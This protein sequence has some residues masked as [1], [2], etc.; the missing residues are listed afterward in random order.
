MHSTQAEILRSP[1]ERKAYERGVQKFNRAVLAW[2]RH[3]RGPRPLREDYVPGYPTPSGVYMDWGMLQEWNERDVAQ[4]ERDRLNQKIPPPYHTPRFQ[5]WLDRQMNRTDTFADYIRLRP[6]D[7]PLRDQ[8]KSLATEPKD[9]CGAHMV[10]LLPHQ[11]VVYA[12]AKLRALNKISSP[13][14]LAM[15]STGAGKTLEGLCAVLAFWDKRI[16]AGQ[17]YA[18]ICV[19]TRSNQNSNTARKLAQLALRFFSGGYTFRSF[20]PG[21][22]EYPFA[23]GTSLDAAEATILKRMQMGL[24]AV[25]SSPADALYLRDN[26]KDLYTY[27]TLANDVAKGRLGS[28]EHLLHHALVIADEVQFLLA[29]PAKELQYRDAYRLL[30]DALTSRRSLAS[31]WVL[32]LTATPGGTRAEACE[33]LNV[34]RGRPGFVTSANLPQKAMGLLSYAQVQGDLHH[35]PRLDLKPVCV[36][37]DPETAWASEYLRVATAFGRFHALIRDL[38]PEAMR[39]IDDNHQTRLTTYR[40]RV[41]TYRQAHRAWKANKR[42]KKADEPQPPQPPPPWSDRETSGPST[43]A[44]DPADRGAFYRRL[45]E[46]SNFI[47]L[48]GEPAE[49]DEREAALQAEKTVV[50]RVTDGTCKSEDGFLVACGPKL[51]QVVK[52]IGKT[53]GKHYVYTSSTTTLLL[54]A[55]LLE[56]ELGMEQ[57]GST[58]HGKKSCTPHTPVAGKKY[59]V[60]LGR[61]ASQRQLMNPAVDLGKWAFGDYPQ[62]L[63]RAAMAAVDMPDNMN[64]EHV[65]VVLTTSEDFKGVDLKGLRYIHLLEPMTD[66]SELIQLAGRGPRFC[67]H[68]GLRPVA[69]KWN[70]TL[71]AYRQMF[72]GAEGTDLNVD[73]HVLQQSIRRFQRQW[74]SD[75]EV[76]LQKASVDYHVFKDNIHQNVA[77]QNQKLLSQSCTPPE[78]HR[79]APT[80]I[81]PIMPLLPQEERKADFRAR[82]QRQLARLGLMDQA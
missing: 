34:V 61:A 63:R 13:G 32:A 58:C 70:V 38:N 51:S 75:T 52:H 19:S 23:V 15:H 42:A 5:V 37:S 53:A 59:F 82:K 48:R 73:S 12:M 14:L 40:E 80:R 35:F 76:A 60:L 17:Y 43:W 25:A 65:K 79:Q 64:G 57:L 46:A 10:D 81:R 1:T 68:A 4:R 7:A 72:E 71:L 41:D 69:S 28:G 36:V 18:I 44:Y 78:V 16:R 2:L 77:G 31:T 6:N 24:Q 29:P 26:R 55:A 45:R 20:V 27:T 50:L 33:I 9:G 39:E 22:P 8:L 30:K 11:A 62:A 74:G 47:F 67:S 21:L 49:L 56:T 66:F 3:K 54:L